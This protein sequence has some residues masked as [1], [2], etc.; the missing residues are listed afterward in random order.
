NIISEHPAHIARHGSIRSSD[1]NPP[2]WL[3]NGHIQTLWAPLFRPKTRPATRRERWELPDNDFLDLAFTLNDS[4]PLVLILHGLQGSIDSPYAGGILKALVDNGYRGVLMHF[5]S[6]SG[7]L[8]RL[9]RLYHSGETGDPLHVI[10]ELRRRFPGV[11][12][13]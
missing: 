1:F 2:W 3:R 9:P 13:A 6:C 4:G 10:S 11:P 12:L 7:E 5:R 8:N